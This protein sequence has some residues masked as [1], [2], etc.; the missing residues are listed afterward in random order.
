MHCFVGT[1]VARERAV[2]EK[3]PERFGARC[4]DFVAEKAKYLSS[5]EKS[6]VA[7]DGKLD[8]GD[9][10]AFQLELLREECRDALTMECWTEGHHHI[11]RGA[12]NDDE[13]QRKY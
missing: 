11:L 5:V 4:Q 1:L 9:R 10:I 12:G 6:P 3:G 7:L 8:E 13:I 2:D